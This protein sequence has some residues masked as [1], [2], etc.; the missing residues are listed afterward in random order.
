M[1]KMLYNVDSGK[2]IET[3]DNNNVRKCILF[4][5]GVID[6]TIYTG[7]TS[8]RDIYHIRKYFTTGAVLTGYSGVKSEIDV[9][10][11]YTRDSQTQ[12]N[13][14]KLK[15]CAEYLHKHGIIESYTIYP[16]GMIDGTWFDGHKSKE[17]K[18]FSS[19]TIPVSVN[20][21]P[22]NDYQKDEIMLKHGT[23]NPYDKDGL[24]SRAPKETGREVW[25]DADRA[26]RVK[27]EVRARSTK[28]IITEIRT[29]RIIPLFK[30]TFKLWEK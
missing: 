15:R 4:V 6:G 30:E 25:Y 2:V 21:N 28:Q 14:N 20:D 16:D 24:P 19:R 29:K 11:E 17:R 18:T 7:H 23:Y 27:G 9:T 22:S 3:T 8:A 26:R 12:R 10:T 13:F 1:S 5:Q